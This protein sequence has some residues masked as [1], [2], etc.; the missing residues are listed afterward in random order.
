MIK[1]LLI[2]CPVKKPET[3]LALM[4]SL[5]HFGLCILIGHYANLIFQEWFDNGTAITGTNALIRRLN[6]LLSL[7]IPTIFLAGHPSYGML[8]PWWLA[9]II[10]STTWGLTTYYVFRFTLQIRAGQK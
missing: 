4:L 9:T 1:Y 2:N 10:N 5:I 6:T 8:W 3:V 7:P